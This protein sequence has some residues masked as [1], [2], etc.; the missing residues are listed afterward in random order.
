MA[1]GPVVESLLPVLENVELIAQA[2]LSA[3]TA[4]QA[5][6]DVH[7]EERFTKTVTRQVLVEVSQ[8]QVAYDAVVVEVH[9][10]VAVGFP[11]L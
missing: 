1:Q 5:S 3:G 4:H 6:H 10:H 11:V 8:H 2:P 7:V 9:G